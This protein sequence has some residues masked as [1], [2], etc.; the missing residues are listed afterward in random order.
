MAPISRRGLI[1]RGSGPTIPQQSY[2]TVHG[3]QGTPTNSSSGDSGSVRFQPALETPEDH[4][5]LSVSKV[6]PVL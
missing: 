1:N 5:G 2:H 4:R 6:G 3:K